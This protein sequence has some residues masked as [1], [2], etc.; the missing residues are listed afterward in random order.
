M[1]TLV[2]ITILFIAN[3]CTTDKIR[4]NS[5]HKYNL[6][7]KVKSFKEIDFEA[8]DKIGK[9]EKGEAHSIKH[10]KF[11]KSGNK[12]EEST[13][14]SNGEL[15]E[16]NI[17][18]YD[19]KYFLKETRRVY[20]YRHSNKVNEYGLPYRSNKPEEI[21]DVHLY[22]NHYNEDGRLL[23]N[24]IKPGSYEATLY[25]LFEDSSIYYYDKNSNLL[26]IKA[27][28]TTEGYSLSN[29]EIRVKEVTVEK[30]EDGLIQMRFNGT[31][32]FEFTGD[33]KV[34]GL[35]ELG[36]KPSTGK[37][38]FEKPIR[39]DTSYSEKYI[40]KNEMLFQKVN[41]FQIN[42]YTTAGDFFSIII[43]YNEFGDEL[44]EST[45]AKDV[46]S[47]KAFGYDSRIL[48]YSYE[49]DNHQNWV[50]KTKYINGIVKSIY[51]RTYEYY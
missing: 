26:E 43:D 25:S 33:S 7:G 6:K 39:F 5:L 42:E 40:Y 18:S 34:K 8:I 51:E 48:T 14:S 49:Y 11:D 30:Y 41:E 19:E 3:S 47:S 24:V 21:N 28:T 44:K 50:V 36:F 17:F 35:M 31:E 10:I 38:K 4:N 20:G 1:R 45:I 32:I 13:Y 29:N 16:K 22:E 15:I 12:V 2:A 27:Y 46:K 23:Y 37:V 9:I